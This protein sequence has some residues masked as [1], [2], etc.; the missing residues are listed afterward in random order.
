MVDKTTQGSVTTMAQERSSVKSLS[1][2]EN[3]WWQGSVI[4]QIYPR[5][6]QDTSGNG[7]GDLPG[8]LN[9]LEHVASLGVD[10]IWLSPF[11]RSPMKDYGYD[12][13]DYRDVD[14]LFGCLDDF[15]AI[16][17][18]AHSLGVKII[19]DQVLNH[20]SDQHEWFKESRLSQDNDKASWF[21]WANPKPDGSPPNNW[22][23]VFG[24]SSWTWEARRGQ[25]YLHNF[26]SSQPD[27][28][29]HNPDVRQQLLDDI[30]FWLKIGVDGL[31]L[32][33]CN[34]Y[35][36]D[37]LLR[38]NPPM[39][40]E[41]EKTRAVTGAN[42][43]SFQRHVYDICQPETIVYHEKIRELLDKYPGT[44]SIGE[45]GADDALDV[46]AQYMADGNK[47]FMAY[48][49]D[50]L[51]TKF[52]PDE[53]RR[54]VSRVERQ[55]KEGWPCWS[56]CNHD[57]V[58]AVSRMP[59]PHTDKQA[60]ILIG[61]LGSLRGS[62]CIYQGEELGLHEAEIPFEKI[63]DPYGLAFW[64]EFKGRDGCRTPMVWDSS[65]SHA[66]FSDAEPWLPVPESHQHSAVDTQIGNADSILSFY[67]NFLKW[68]QSYE[69]LKRG[70]FQWMD[71]KNSQGLLFKRS[72]QGESVLVAINL[73]AEDLSFKLTE[74]YSLENIGDFYVTPI[75]GHGFNGKWNNER[76]TIDL[77]PYDGFFG[78]FLWCLKPCLLKT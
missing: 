47:L 18:K 6:Y 50:L 62:L 74:I 11:F 31:R 42:P 15:K 14:P 17:E 3:T 34:F 77:A 45:I 16:V 30:E 44:T 68:R 59:E 64:P 57:V 52:D 69:V 41:D 33:A 19:I 73:S 65:L 70:T 78:L 20:C 28:N 5:S 2:E 27:L 10:A 71:Y 38:D 67:Q 13:S 48:T 23:S 22:L 72:Y 25:Y 1:S 60:K 24:G 56:F 53:I 39:D 51:T 36:H 55:L 46:M 7:V 40:K 66:G 26:L 49:F 29:F 9:R 35:Y 8:I 43:Y 4:Y 76:K 58:R 61:L 63:Q 37:A 21:V 32:D 54:I 12:V 75:D